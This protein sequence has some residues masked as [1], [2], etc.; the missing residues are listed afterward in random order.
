M[1]KELISLGSMVDSIST[2]RAFVRT[3]CCSAFVYRLRHVQVGLTP[4][5]K[6]S[7]AGEHA[8]LVTLLESGAEV[9]RQDK[10]RALT[11]VHN[12][13]RYGT[14]AGNTALHHAAQCGRSE[15]VNTLLQAGA[16]AEMRNKV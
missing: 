4:L 10:A 16:G 7:S 15:C 14:Q 3:C 1:V 2:V 8:V 9:D 12:R 11:F 13:S 6:A 5:H